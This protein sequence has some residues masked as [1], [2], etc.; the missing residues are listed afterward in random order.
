LLLKH[1]DL[2]NFFQERR[3]IPDR[4]FEF[5]QSVF[6]VD[7]NSI[8]RNSE[9]AS[10]AVVGSGYKFPKQMMLGYLSQPVE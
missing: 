4:P 8:A 1:G 3:N 6:S 5:P 9:S 10:G 2:Y 7:P